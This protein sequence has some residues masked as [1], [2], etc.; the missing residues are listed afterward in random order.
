MHNLDI[1]YIFSQDIDEC[2]N[3]ILIG[4][5]LCPSEMT[6]VNTEGS[7]YCKCSSGYINNN[8]T[9][10]SKNSMCSNNKNDQGYVSHCT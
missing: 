6:C 4:D 8:G 3:A 9:C 1:S 2:R 7:F 10:K 5:K